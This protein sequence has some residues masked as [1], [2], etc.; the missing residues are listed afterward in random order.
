MPNTVVNNHLKPIPTPD[1]EHQDIDGGDIDDIG[2]SKNRVLQR[3]DIEGR[4]QRIEF[5]KE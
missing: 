4:V 2:S 3:I 1:R 5:F